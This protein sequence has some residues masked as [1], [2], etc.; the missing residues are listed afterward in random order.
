MYSHSIYFCERQSKGEAFLVLFEYL[1]YWSEEVVFVDDKMSHIVDVEAVLQDKGVKV[2]GIHYT[3]L[4]LKKDQF[5]L[6]PD[7]LD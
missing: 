2:H 7:L 4:A 3:K 1:Y 6:P 5:K